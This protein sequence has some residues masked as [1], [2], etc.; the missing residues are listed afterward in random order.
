MKRF[1]YFFL[2]MVLLAAGAIVFL[3]RSNPEPEYE[4]RPITSWIG[5]LVSSDYEIHNKAATAVEAAGAGAVPYLVSA[6]HKR[7]TVLMRVRAILAARLPFLRL[8]VVDPSLLRQR[9]AEQLGVVPG[10]GATV[11]PALIAALEDDHLDV[12]SEIQR[13]LRR[14]GPPSLPAL[15]AALRCPNARI[16][17][18][19]AEVITDFGYAA[20]SAVPALCSALKDPD[21][22][23]RSNAARALGTTSG[24]EATAV[25]ALIL[26][27]DDPVPAV[28]TAASGSLGTLGPLAKSATAAL[29]RALSDRDAGGRV[30]AAK[31]LWLVGGQPD[32]VVPVLIEAL[33]D[34]RV[35][36]QAS[37][38]LGEIGPGAGEAAS[39]LI[40]ALKQEKV[41]RALRAPPSSAVALGRI[42][43]AAVPDLIRTLQ[44]QESSARTSAA[45]ALGM[46]GPQAEQA[47]PGL[48]RLLDDPDEEVRQASVLSL[49]AIA[50]QTK[51]L[52]PALLK[53]M[54]E[55]DIFI[56]SMAA[57]VLQRIDSGAAAEVRRLEK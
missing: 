6:L 12:S 15:V 50:P 57:A 13:A 36:W 31:A 17:Q 42:G 7:E 8:R 30:A 20:R 56:R 1:W 19:S 32:R 35:R 26:G 52:L 5:D 54:G 18:R 29:S 53:M 39:A 44:D 48:V 40:A 3:A 55:D 28:R 46:M 38:V 45:I 2:L 16:R 10:Q 14:I 9:A 49:G 43:R 37:F 51:E 27:L 22:G 41:P 33:Q 47:I 11:V 24:G 34:P 25:A 4:G 23:V 21:E